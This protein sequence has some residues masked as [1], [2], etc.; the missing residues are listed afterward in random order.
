M[1]R[2]RLL[3]LLLAGGVTAGCAA[4]NNDGAILVL[5]NVHADTTCTFTG[6]LTEASIPHG[7]LDILIPTDYLFTAQMESRIVATDA[8]V[9]TRTIITRAA[10][11][12]VA[13]P[14]STLFT[15]AELADMQKSGLTHFRSN[16]ST[17]ILPNDGVADGTF[18]LIPA[19]LAQKVLEKSGVTGVSDAPFRI[20]AEATFTIE[21]DLSGATVTSQPFTYG[22]TLG[23]NVSIVPNP[24]ACSTS[25]GGT[26]LRTGYACNPL[27]DGAVDCCTSTSG[28]QVLLS[29]PSTQKTN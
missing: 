3:S 24:P 12:D 15:A 20:E 17:P 22:V 28:T 23:N 16:V 19:A 10:K 13:F 27:Q 9:D 21:G 11:V 26:T 29:C 4:D 25:A 8:Q 2:G 6:L 7:S 5:K 18:V 14:N 1:A